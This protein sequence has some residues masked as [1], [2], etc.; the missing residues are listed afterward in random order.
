MVERN[1][2]LFSD[3][4]CRGNPGVG[5]A[6]AVITDDRENVVWEGKKYLGHCTNNIAEY[7][8]LIM[9]LNGALD[10]GYKNLEVYLD[11]ELLARQIN[12]SYRV[13]NENLKI[14][15]KDIRG[16]LS[17]FDSVAVRHVPRLHN[18]HA[19]RL[20]NLAIDEN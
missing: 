3:G 4:A 10:N 17:S 12:G 14:L 16:L 13:K 11:S 7:R 5:G 9:G 6:G 8:A 1:Y 18:S 19:D 15:M 20:A 2:K